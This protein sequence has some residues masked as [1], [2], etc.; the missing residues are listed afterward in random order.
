MKTSHLASIAGLGLL[1]LAAGPLAAGGIDPAA[2][3]AGPAPQPQVSFSPYLRAEVGSLLP[4]LSDAYWLPPGQADPRIDF[5]L[6]GDNAGFASAAF[7]IDWN[8]GLRT[9]LALIH[10]GDIG[11]SGPCASA[12]DGSDCDATPHADIT[13]GTVRSRA[14][15]ANLF[16]APLEGRNPDARIQP[17]VVGGLGVAWNT[18]ESWTRFNPQAGTPP[19]SRPFRTFGSNTENDVAWSI[20]IGASWCLTDAETP[21]VMDVTWRYYDFGEAVGGDVADVGASVPRQ[22]LTFDLSS[23]VFSLGVRIPLQ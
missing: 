21:I 7:G 1:V 22:P 11:F 4:E 16:Y 2:P 20:G 8:N 19:G 17:F 3:E 18:V 13:D 23:Q 15:M 10:T 6:D 9:D 14:M 5:D 12:S